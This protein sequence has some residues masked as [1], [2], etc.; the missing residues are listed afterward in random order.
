MTFADII[1][2]LAVPTC[3]T[4]RIKETDIPTLKV[5]MLVNVPLGKS[6]HYNGI[7]LKIHNDAK[8]G[9]AYKEIT[10]VLLPEPIVT[11]Q[12]INLWNWIS[13]YYMCKMGYVLKVAIPNALFNTSYKARSESWLR[14]KVAD[15]MPLF[16][17]RK[18]TEQQLSL[19]NHLAS[20]PNGVTLADAQ[21]VA[22]GSVINLLEKRG[23]VE[24]FTTERS[25]FSYE[26]ELTPS[27]RLSAVQQKA[28]E[29]IESLFASDSK[30][31]LLHGITSSGKTEIYIKLIEKTISEGRQVLFLV[32]EIALTTQLTRRL[33]KI[34][35]DT[36]LVYHSKLSDQ[37]R[38]EVYKDVQSNE[39]YKIVLGV[40]SAVFLPFR[41]LGLVII[42]E[43]HDS[44]Y[45]QQ[46]PQPLYNAV[47]CA[48]MLAIDYKAKV[49]MGSATPSI[50]GYYNAVAGK[51][52]LVE[53]MSRYKEIEPPHIE[54]VDMKV[55]R[56]KRK[57]HSM[58]SWTL[59]DK[60]IEAVSAG[61]QVILFHNRRGYASLAQCE[62]CGWV[63]KC[64]KCSVS[65]TYHKATETL[66]C[67]YCGHKEPMPLFCPVCGENLST[68]GYGTEQ[69][70]AAI[71]EFLPDAKVLRLDLDTT[72][73]K[74][75][76]KEILDRF[77]RR[78]ADILLGTQ[79]VSKGLDFEGV[80]LVGV[81][82][83]DTMLDYPDFRSS[84]LSFQTLLQV[85]GRSGRSKKQGEVVL[86]T[87]HA[88]YPIIEQIVDSDYV[89]FYNEQITIRHLFSYPPF[90]RVMF[91]IVRSRNQNAAL[92]AANVIAESLKKVMPDAVLGPEEPPVGK[93]Q[94]FYYKRLMVKTLL[95]L[96][97]ASVKNSVSYVIE[98]TKRNFGGVDIYVDV[99]PI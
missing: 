18:P 25:R 88:E 53:L 10:S 14:L 55:E 48:I 29:A 97:V 32:P 44:S 20:F 23:V 1:L 49:V 22:S 60:V 64:E 13:S 81:I 7:V 47:S 71:K 74:N 92:K 6:K 86:Q 31:V 66:E 43:Q 65:L 30:P 70:E 35:G 73:G 89:A 38:A 58:F 72:K 3:Y 42:D 27:S 15:W 28:L 39:H 94:N 63:P 54:V 95:P 78:E 76:Y 16:E 91:I 83:A 12:Q 98:E 5:G 93:I 52:H 33:E 50:E 67:H 82:N 11:Q 62:K 4:Y 69:V 57:V 51:W 96:S 99:D 56:K 85:A 36:L 37:E 68:I 75:S 79:M 34:F 45:K 46:E 2:P 24:K 19:L 17:K 77:G 80:S 21:D 8:P 84:E 40:R 87:S 90:C 41:N 9:I 59:R 61:E 26:G